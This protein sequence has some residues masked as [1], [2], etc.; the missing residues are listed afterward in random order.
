MKLF[1]HPSFTNNAFVD[2]EKS[3]VFHS[4]FTD[5]KVRPYWTVKPYHIDDVVTVEEVS[6]DELIRQ[7]TEN[8]LY[9]YENTIEAKQG[10]ISTVKRLKS[11]GQFLFFSLILLE[12]EKQKTTFKRG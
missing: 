3:P 1:Y 10:V 8:M 6:E 2:F 9:A 12:K 11:E 4:S 5:N 7:F